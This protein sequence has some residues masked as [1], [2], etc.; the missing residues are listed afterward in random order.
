M[1]NV[2][3]P[4]DQSM[5]A[6]STLVDAEGIDLRTEIYVLCSDEDVLGSISACH[7]RRLQQQLEIGLLVALLTVFGATKKESI[8]EVRSAVYHF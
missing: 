4:R 6:P 1:A 2:R 5:F 8:N 3:D 7:A